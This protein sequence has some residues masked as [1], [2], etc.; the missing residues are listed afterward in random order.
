MDQKGKN[1]RK[2]EF[3]GMR[4]YVLVHCRLNPFTGLISFENGQ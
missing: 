2:A 4:N 3:L 1:K